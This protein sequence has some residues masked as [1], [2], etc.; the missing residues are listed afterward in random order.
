MSKKVNSK[1]KKKRLT[2]DGGE[3]TDEGEMESREVDYM[4]DS[5]SNSEL[6]FLVIRWNGSLPG[7]IQNSLRL[8]VCNLCTSIVGL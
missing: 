6:E 5:S 3:D 8:A 1:K 4:S 7:H 2:V